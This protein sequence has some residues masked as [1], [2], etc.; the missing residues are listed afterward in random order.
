MG[1]GKGTLLCAVKP[2]RMGVPPSIAFDISKSP[3]LTNGYSLRGEHE[4]FGV[5]VPQLVS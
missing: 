5:I 3:H 1:G 4:E 2:Y